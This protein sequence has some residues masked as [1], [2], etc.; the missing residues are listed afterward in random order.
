MKKIK[1]LTVLFVAF[2]TVMILQGCYTQMESTKKVKV[3]RRPV[4][5]TKNL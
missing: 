4:Y 2:S 3:T 5:K 1:N